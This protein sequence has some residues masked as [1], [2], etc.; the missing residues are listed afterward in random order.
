[1]LL[2]YGKWRARTR[3]TAAPLPVD[4][5]PPRRKPG[6]ARVF[7]ENQQLIT[8]NNARG[9]YFPIDFSSEHDTLNPVENCVSSAGAL[10][11]LFFFK[12]GILFAHQ[13]QV[14]LESELYEL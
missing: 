4:P 12:C 2:E 8:Q 14:L 11:P 9:K 13:K 7:A 10:L 3:K 5:L 6:L 1:M